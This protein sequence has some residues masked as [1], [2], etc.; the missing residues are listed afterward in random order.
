MDLNL[1]FFF[2]FMKWHAC[3]ANNLFLYIIIFKYLWV[4]ES[5]YVTFGCTAHTHFYVDPESFQ[6]WVEYTAR[7][8]L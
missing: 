1:Y 3:F 2:S 7:E 6:S 4:L 5:I 8:D